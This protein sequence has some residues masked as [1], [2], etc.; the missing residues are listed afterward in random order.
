M[1]SKKC[2][3]QCQVHPVL[4]K[5]SKLTHFMPLFSFYTPGKNQETRHFLMFSRGKESDQRHE[6]GQTECHNRCMSHNQNNY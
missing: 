6:M 1:I 5:L 3:K 4:K 2:L